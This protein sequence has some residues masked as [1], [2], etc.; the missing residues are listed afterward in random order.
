METGIIIALITSLT[1][2]IVA[3]SSIYQS[4]R[5][6]KSNNEA[7][8]SLEELKFDIEIKRKRKDYEEK[9]LEERIAGLSLTVKEIQLLKDRLFIIISSTS[10]SLLSQEAMDYIINSRVSLFSCYESILAEVDKTDAFLIHDAKNISLQ[11]ETV[12]KSFLTDKKYLELT[13]SQKQILRD[14]RI[15]LNDIQTN[16]RNIKSDL[17][18]DF[19]R[20]YGI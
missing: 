7:S 2:L 8:K 18:F 4:K 1:S 16:L 12:F 17:I 20:N 14:F 13:E 6:N 3:L 9:L 15:N 10:E 11:I 19:S 5:T